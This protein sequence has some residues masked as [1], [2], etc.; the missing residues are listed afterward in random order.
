MD[1][2]NEFEKMVDSNE[3]FLCRGSAK[4]KARMST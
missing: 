2:S 3:D 1:G 4:V